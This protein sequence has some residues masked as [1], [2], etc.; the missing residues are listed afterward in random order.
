VSEPKQLAFCC[1]D[2]AIKTYSATHNY[3]PEADRAQDAVEAAEEDLKELK[4]A[5]QQVYTISFA[6]RQGAMLQ[7][8]TDADRNNCNALQDE[9]QLRQLVQSVAQ[10]H[11]QCQAIISRASKKLALSQQEL[12]TH[13]ASQAQQAAQD[14]QAAA[15]AGVSSKSR[16]LCWWKC[17]Q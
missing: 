11:S 7:R 17:W 12:Q 16:L 2:P 1:S 5:N 15:D 6:C 10:T 8:N 14:A 13:L 3:K 4:K 9:D